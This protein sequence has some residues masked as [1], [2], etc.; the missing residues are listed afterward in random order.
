MITDRYQ[1]NSSTVNSSKVNSSTPFYTIKLRQ[2]VLF[3]GQ[4]V[5]SQNSS[6]RHFVVQGLG[7]ESKTE[8]FAASH[9]L[10][11]LRTMSQFT[12]ERILLRRLWLIRRTRYA[13]VTRTKAAACFPDLTRF[14]HGQWQ[15]CDDSWKLERSRVPGTTTWTIKC[16]H[17]IPTRLGKARANTQSLFTCVNGWID[18]GK[19]QQR[20]V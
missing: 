14:H 16:T 19:I 17:I 15:W 5:C 11:H 7:I 3:Y 9:I 1:V 6:T 10:T 8:T 13:K 12:F 20:L 18:E 4:L 2:G